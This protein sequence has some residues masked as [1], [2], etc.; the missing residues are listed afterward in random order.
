MSSL[1]GS[2]RDMI[3]KSPAAD[4]NAATTQ[5]QPQAP[6]KDPLSRLSH[7]VSVTPP[8]KQGPSGKDSKPT[9]KHP[10]HHS[11]SI[12]STNVGPTIGRG[13]TGTQIMERVSQTPL[14]QRINGRST[15]R[16]SAPVTSQ[17]VSSRTPAERLSGQ[18]GQRSAS[19]LAG[20]GASLRNLTR[21]SEVP[22]TPR[23]SNVPLEQDLVDLPT[24]D[25]QE[26]TS[27]WGVFSVAS[28][29]AMGVAAA[30]LYYWFQRR[31]GNANTKP[32]RKLRKW[33]VLRL[34]SAADED[35][36]HHSGYRPSHEFNAMER[37]SVADAMAERA[38]YAC[39]MTGQ[40]LRPRKTR[41][42]LSPRDI[43]ISDAVRKSAASYME[44]P[45]AS[46]EPTMWERYSKGGK[47]N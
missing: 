35:N 11:A 32:E 26:S 44:M 12:K 1:I 6:H 20:L 8:P 10:H 3:T 24:S 17:S 16:Q 38:S 15:P 40:N 30:G 29:G 34:V 31:F 7:G 33:E 4:Q 37:A 28:F 25:I 45:R 41:A 27:G 42:T 36:A 9:R 18:N 22:E 21:T 47:L 5:A 14:H 2:L 43:H 13:S 39:A 19:P 46:H 23:E